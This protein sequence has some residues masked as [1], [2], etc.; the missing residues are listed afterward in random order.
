ML[1]NTLTCPVLLPCIY[2][3]IIYGWKLLLQKPFFFPTCGP[4]TFGL[5]YR[6]VKLKVSFIKKKKS[7]TCTSLHVPKS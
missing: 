7:Q 5:K 2:K 6:M 3:S 4:A 1:S